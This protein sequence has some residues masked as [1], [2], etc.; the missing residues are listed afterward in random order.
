MGDGRHARV[1]CGP[2]I[3]VT[4]THW[5][6][7]RRF[8]SMMIP[9]MILEIER[10]E[11]DKGYPTLQ[12]RQSVVL[13]LDPLLLALKNMSDHALFKSTPLPINLLPKK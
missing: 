6:V 9:F 10:C 5:R 12:N 7:F 13:N 2:T 4:S 8:L 11:G 1:P 3:F